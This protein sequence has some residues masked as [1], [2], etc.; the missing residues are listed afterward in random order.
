MTNNETM[1]IVSRQ[2]KLIYF[3]INCDER[4]SA[5]EEGERD[6]AE[7]NHKFPL[8]LK[9]VNFIEWKRRINYFPLTHI[10]KKCYVTHNDCFAA[11]IVRSLSPAS[12]LTDPKCGKTITSLKNKFAL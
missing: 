9:S 7:K 2:G 5:E 6:G 10:V 4:A 12:D 8:G 11:A 1:R 3:A